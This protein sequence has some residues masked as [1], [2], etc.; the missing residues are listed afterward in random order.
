MGVCR[1]VPKGGEITGEITYPRYPCGASSG[2]IPDELDLQISQDAEEAP[3]AVLPSLLT[4]L[5][6][7]SLVGE[8]VCG[9]RA[10]A[11]DRVHALLP[12]PLHQLHRLQV[13]LAAGTHAR[14]GRF[15]FSSLLQL[16]HKPQAA[17]PCLHPHCP[18]GEEDAAHGLPDTFPSLLHSTCR[19]LPHEHPLLLH[20][21]L[22]LRLRPDGRLPAVTVLV[23]VPHLLLALLPGVRGDPPGMGQ[24]EQGL[25]GAGRGWA[26]R[27]PSGAHGRSCAPSLPWQKTL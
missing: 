5:P 18:Q 11:G 15:C 16:A 26:A 4:G 2:S 25:G 13:F 19:H 12:T 8:D 7:Q 9:Q 1:W 23:G 10:L 24:A 17:E 27:H 20:L 14:G 3:L 21:P 6:N 22:A